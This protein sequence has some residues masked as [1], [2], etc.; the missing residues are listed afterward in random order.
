[1]PARLPLM[2]PRHGRILCGVCRGI[3]LH[4]GVSVTWVRLAML[5]LTFAF[6]IGM[7][8]Y[9]LLWIFVPVGDPYVAAQAAASTGEH[10]PL[11]RGNA[12]SAS[13]PDEKEGTEAREGLLDVLRGASKPVLLI[14]LGALLLTLALSFLWRGL[15]GHLV[16]PALL[17]GA[18]IAVAWLRFDGARHRVSTLALSACLILAALASYVFPV[19][20]LREAWQ[21]MILTLAV[22]ASVAVVLT[23]WAQALLQR[24]SSERAG[25]EREEERADMAAHLHDGVLQTLALIQLNADDPQTVFTLARG[26]ERDLRDWLYQER[27]PTDRSV[28]SGLKQIAAQI[29]DEHGQPIDVVTVGDAL[30]SAQTDALLDAARQAL[31]NAVTHGGEPI[32]LYCEAG[33]SKVEV[34]VRDHGDGF[35]PAAIPP[36]RLGIRQSIIGRIERRGGTVEIVSRP[37]WGTEVRMHM[38]ISAASQSDQARPG[39]ATRTATDAKTRLE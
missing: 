38:P 10:S 14:G 12:P 28:S 36:D 29:E 23:P 26:Q 18:G 31:L 6:G 15:P 16:L 8:A 21:M 17:L 34:F 35:D 2:R 19:F 1:M 24:I 32:A 13:E 7:A 11:S 20:P 30:P 33:K 39:T 4:L 27:T 25:K 22:L 37:G 9:I 3:S 5:A